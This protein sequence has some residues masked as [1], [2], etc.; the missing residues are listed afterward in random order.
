MCCP[1]CRSEYLMIKQKKGFERIRI[2]FTG[3]REY[4]CRDCDTNF[5]GPDRRRV[6]REEKKIATGLVLTP[7]A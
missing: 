2:Y 1:K 7:R 3:L 6:P 5:R 4:L